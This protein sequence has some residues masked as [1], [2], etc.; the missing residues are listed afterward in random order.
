M[1]TKDGLITFGKFKNE[2]LE[3]VP[4]A[5]LKWLLAER[6]QE[7]GELARELRRRGVLPGKAEK[8]GAKVEGFK[9][10][11]RGGSMPEPAGEQEPEQ[12]RLG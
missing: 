2:K 1:M 10:S 7:V 4:D 8:P 5:Y 11:A 6:Q 3:D 12:T 9:S